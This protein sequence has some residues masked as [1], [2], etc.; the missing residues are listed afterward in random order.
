M[1]RRR[2]AVMMRVEVRA[3]KG[4][5]KWVLLLSLPLLLVTAVSA[6]AK[7]APK[8]I[9]KHAGAPI[10]ALAI[11]GAR[12]V[13][14][15]DDNG[16][17]VWNMQS[18]ATVRVR[19]PSPTDFPQIGQ[20]AIAGTRVA[21]ITDDVA[22]NS[23]ETNEDLFTASLGSAAKPK[24]AHAYR[25]F[26]LDLGQWRGDWISGL[27]GS[28]KLLAVS[29]WTTTPTPG[30]GGPEAI[31]NGR[32]S[33]IAQE[34]GQLQTVASGESAIVSRS[35]DGG[36]VAVLRATGTVGIYSGTGALLREITPGPSP[37]VE[38]ALSEG[39]LVVLTKSQRLEVYNAQNGI[40]EHRWVIGTKHYYALGNVRAY[41][42]LAVFAVGVGRIP[43]S[44]RIFD[45]Q[46][47]RSIAL[48]W[49]DR[50]AWN[51]ASVGPLGIVYAVNDYRAYGGHHPNGTLVFLSTARVL[52]GIAH[53]H[54]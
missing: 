47:G 44:M 16:V 8:R 32:L 46:T 5:L 1:T 7:S 48:P 45:L 25:Y 19:R 20:V 6:S 43:R 39:R 50:S 18:G 33:R 23:M 36:R 15:T 21:W 49:R 11:D 51:D 2:L 24:R 52:D 4:L 14:S 53:G 28:G 35:V 37:P 10:A 29:T 54:L 3:M 12:V 30:V 41:R 9:L 38:I 34:R 22:G 42:G 17:Y 13:Y 27:V 26:D 40:L 31:S